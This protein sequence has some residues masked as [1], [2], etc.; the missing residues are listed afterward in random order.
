LRITYR[1]LADA[2]LVDE[3][4]ILEPNQTVAFRTISLDV[5]P[6]PL[7]PIDVT[8]DAAP[9]IPAKFEPFYERMAETNGTFLTR[10]DFEERSPR[11]IITAL[12]NVQGIRV[13][14]TPSGDLVR[15]SR[16]PF[17]GGACPSPVVFLDG[18]FVGGGS[19]YLDIDALA[20]TSDVEG[21]EIYNG[22]A[23]IPI[24]LNRADSVCGVIVIW[25]R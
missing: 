19:E 25:T 21:I 4:L 23:Q 17:A 8:V 2:T 9:V 3:S 13:S 15:L 22:S 18:A 5:P 12:R 1:S 6:V 20:A 7:D 16:A 14:R 11:T 24:E 10:E